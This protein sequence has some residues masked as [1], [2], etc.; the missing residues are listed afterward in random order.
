[1][2]ISR[3][4]IDAEKI[5]NGIVQA[6][7]PTHFLCE[8]FKNLS[9]KEDENLRSIIQELC[10]TGYIDVSMWASNEPYHV[11]GKMLLGY[12]MCN[13]MQIEIILE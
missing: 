6:E 13:S 11:I 1:M 8:C 10:Q 3:L 9:A 5:L 7:N 12:A 4:S 2:E